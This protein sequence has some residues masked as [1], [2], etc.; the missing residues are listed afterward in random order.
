MKLIRS[1]VSS[2]LSFVCAEPERRIQRAES[3]DGR[4]EEYGAK[5]EQDDPESAGDDASKIE[6]GKQGGDQDS[7]SAVGVGHVAFHC[8]ISFGIV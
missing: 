3:Q 6:V 2:I 1:T 8:E 4:Q 7:D 5:H